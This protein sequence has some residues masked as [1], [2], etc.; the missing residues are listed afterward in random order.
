M[1]KL[2]TASET[3][4]CDVCGLEE[5][6]AEGPRPGNHS[7]NTRHWQVHHVFGHDPI[8]LCP[9]CIDLMA[10]RRNAA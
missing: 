10:A 5:E 8:R 2:L 6:I 4:T 7:P 1:T 3:Q 9:E